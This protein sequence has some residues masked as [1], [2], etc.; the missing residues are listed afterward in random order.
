MTVVVTVSPSFGGSLQLAELQRTSAHP[1]RAAHVGVVLDSQALQKERDGLCNSKPDETVKRLYDGYRLE[2]IRCR[3]SFVLDCLT[4][5]GTV[6]ESCPTSNLRIGGVPRPEDHPVHRFLRSDVNLAI[7][8]DD[9]GVFGT[10]LADE[11]EWVAEHSEWER[12]RLAERLGDPFRFRMG[13]D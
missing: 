2:E 5:M 1:P 12:S 10:T 8:A 3:Q 9:P 7:C 11:V 6:I 4:E 13:K